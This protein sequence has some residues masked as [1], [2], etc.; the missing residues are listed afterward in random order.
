MDL[1]ASMDVLYM[2]KKLM[3]VLNTDPLIASQIYSDPYEFCPYLMSS[4]FKSLK[5][6]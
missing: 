6:D 2:K 3:T 5:R 1:R 4:L